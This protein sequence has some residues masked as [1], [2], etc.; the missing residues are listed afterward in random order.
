M[1]HRWR[2]CRSINFT[3]LWPINRPLGIDGVSE[4]RTENVQQESLGRGHDRPGERATTT[5]TVH[6]GWSL[7]PVPRRSW[8]PSLARQRQ[9]RCRAGWNKNQTRKKNNIKKKGI[10]C[11]GVPGR[12]H[13][14]VRRKLSFRMHHHTNTHA[15]TVVQEERS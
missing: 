9:G 7:L 1:L 5:T 13:A 11:E 15:N 10:S 8:L 4:D 12:T 14:A 2:W 6:I 3:L